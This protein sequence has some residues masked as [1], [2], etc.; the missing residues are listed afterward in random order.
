MMRAI[1]L[2]QAMMRAI[3]LPQAM[4]RARRLPQIIFLLNGSALSRITVPATVVT[5]HAA[6]GILIVTMPRW[7]SMDVTTL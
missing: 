6:R 3:R 4:M 1:R 5:A 2:P 7:V